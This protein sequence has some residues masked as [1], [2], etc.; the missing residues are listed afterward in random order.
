MQETISFA[1]DDKLPQSKASDYIGYCR[2]LFY[3]GNMGN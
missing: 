1:E 2:K 3:Q